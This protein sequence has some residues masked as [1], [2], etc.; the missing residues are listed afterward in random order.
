[1]G[2]SVKNI[3]SNA[4]LTE[5]DVHV[6]MKNLRVSLEL[7]PFFQNKLSGQTMSMDVVENQSNGNQGVQSS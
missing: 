3:L 1:M 7:M 4:N 6:I 2:A 5:S